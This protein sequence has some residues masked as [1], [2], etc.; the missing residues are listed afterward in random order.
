MRAMLAAMMVLSLLASPSKADDTVHCPEPGTVITYNDGNSLTFTNQAGNTCRARN[1]KGALVSLFVG[2]SFPEVDQEKYHAERL[3]PLRIGS[4]IDFMTS[5]NTQNATGD[6]V[7]TTKDV[8]YDNTI[9]VARQEKVTTAAGTFDT[10][11]IEWHRQARGRWSGAWL[12]TVWFAPDLGSLIKSKFKTRQGYGPDSS[13]EIASI[14]APK[15]TN[16]PIA[17]AVPTP[18]PQTMAGSPPPG[19]ARALD[20]VKLDQA[21]GQLLVAV[22]VNGKITL[23]FILDS[24]AADVAIPADVVQTLRGT[25]T[26]SNADFIGTKT[27]VLADGSKLPG[28]AFILHEVRVGDHVVKNI[29]AG[30]SPVQGKLLLGQSFLSRLP[31]WTIDNKQHALIIIGDPADAGTP[32]AVERVAA[33]PQPRA[34]APPPPAPVPAAAPVPRPQ[35][36]PAPSPAG[37]RW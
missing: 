22:E 19:N 20:T 13:V 33:T 8:Y 18:S 5:G 27:Y 7:N 28:E 36:Q 6:L 23:N 12:S 3:L 29:T 11:V 16:A 24:G 25:G 4:Q 2:L 17:R 14:I 15:G 34:P 32:A 9:T 1:G 35:P 21:N 26:V 37:C 10:Y 30:V 31:A